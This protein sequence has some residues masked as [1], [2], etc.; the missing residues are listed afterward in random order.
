MK[1]MMF[2]DCGAPSIYNE[3]ARKR[4]SSNKALM[5]STFKDRKNDSHEYIKSKF[6]LDYLDEY[7]DF[8]CTMPKTESLII[9]ALDVIND[10]KNTYR[11]WLKFIERGV[12]AIPCWHLGSDV[13]YLRKYLSEHN[14]EFIAIGGMTPNPYGKLVGPL[15]KIWQN[16]LCDADGY[17]KAKY[18]GFAMTSFKLMFRYPWYSVD[19]SSANATARF[20]MVWIPNR[21][22]D[23]SDPVVVVTSFHVASNSKKKYWLNSSKHNQE[24]LEDYVKS[25]GFSLGKSVV[26]KVDKGYKPIP[27]KEFWYDKGNL[28]VAEVIEPGLTNNFNQRWLFNADFLEESSKTVPEWPWQFKS[29]R[30]GFFK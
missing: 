17:P 2:L 28:E 24:V 11:I 25:R 19:S 13:T 12:N 14:C 4:T 22:K 8:C 20:G 5:G 29:K 23:Y 18:H 10:P 16:D 3:Y 1:K 21:Y 30:R 6:F 7:I 15:D 27:L 9:T 26:R